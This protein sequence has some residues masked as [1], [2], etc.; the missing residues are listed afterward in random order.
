MNKYSDVVA[1]FD[2]KFVFELSGESP[3]KA[4]DSD[5]NDA[6]Q[7][8]GFPLPEDYREFLRDFGGYRLWALFTSQNRPRSGE[9]HSAGNLFGLN[10]G[11]SCNLVELYKTDLVNK[12]ISPEL[13]PITGDEEGKVCIFLDGP[14]KG[15]VH[16]WVSEEL[17]VPYDFSNLYFVANSFDEFMRSLYP[18]PED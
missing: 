10:I 15:T 13:L 12:V 7:E 3:V 4:T 18:V 6:E 9:E 8:I 14:Q 17:V 16:F 11:Y 5:L 2:G 1:K